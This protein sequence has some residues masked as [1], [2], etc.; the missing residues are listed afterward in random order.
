M[1]ATA[2]LLAIGFRHG[3][4]AP[5]VEAG[6]ARFGALAGGSVDYDAFRDAVAA[7][8]RDGLIHDPVRLVDGALQ[9]HWCLELTAAGVARARAMMGRAG[10]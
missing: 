4:T 9:C 5:D 10:G 3:I 8:V 2:A 7:C 1:D 6:F